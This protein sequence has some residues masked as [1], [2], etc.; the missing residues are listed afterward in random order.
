MI[1]ARFAPL[2]AVLDDPIGERALEADVVTGLFRLN[3]LVAENLFAF[4]L[5][6][7]IQLG[8][9]EEVCTPRTIFRVI[10]HNK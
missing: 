9:L 6:L 5:K 7:A 4:G 10:R 2:G 3:P 1:L 8:I